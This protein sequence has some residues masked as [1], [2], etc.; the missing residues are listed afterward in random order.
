M[1]VYVLISYKN[2]ND[3]YHGFLVFFEVAEYTG[4]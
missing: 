2:E 3:E 1:P 4:Y